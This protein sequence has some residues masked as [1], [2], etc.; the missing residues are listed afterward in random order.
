MVHII[1]AGKISSSSSTYD[2]LRTFLAYLT[3]LDLTK[4]A[5]CVSGEPNPNEDWHL[6]FDVVILDSRQVINYSSEV[7]KFTYKRLQHEAERALGIFDEGKVAGFHSLFT[8]PVSFLRNFD[9]IV[10]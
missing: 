10:Q 6:Q 2:V 3:K 1:S 4:K 5:I 7:S 9:H 8:T